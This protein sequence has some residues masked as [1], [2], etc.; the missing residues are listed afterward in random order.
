MNPVDWWHGLEGGAIAEA[1]PP[2]PNADAPYPNLSSVPAKPPPP[3][4]RAQQGVAAGLTA[5][6]NNAHYAAVAEPIPALPK[7]A[8]RPAAAP[9]ASGDADEQPNAALQAAHA[10]PAAPAAPSPAA[11]PAA[12]APGAPTALAGAAPAMPDIPPAPPS[13]PVLAGVDVPAVTA[14]TPPP[15]APPAPPAPPP[16]PG[17]PVAIAFPAGSAI[18]PPAAQPSLKA[19]AAQRGNRW[20]AVTGFGEASDDAPAVQT[21]ALPLALDR[22]RAVAAALGTLGVPGWALR[23][24]ALPGGSGAVARLVD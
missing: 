18:L 15:V 19:L 7:P 12:Q 14:P 6:R 5:D 22:A 11:V 13:P 8:P 4:A 17:A 20:I 16:A 21:A 1:R 23:I 9:T 2:P 24:V 3:D 10:A